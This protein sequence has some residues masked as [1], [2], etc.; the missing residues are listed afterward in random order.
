MAQIFLETYSVTYLLNLLK[1]FKTENIKNINIKILFLNDKSNFMTY[2]I[3]Y[4]FFK[5]IEFKK[6][7]FSFDGLKDQENITLGYKIEKKI[8]YKLFEKIYNNEY[9]NNLNSKIDKFN[10]FAIFLIKYASLKNFSDKK[11]LVQLLITIYACLDKLKKKNFFPKKSIYIIG[12]CPWTNEI[13]SIFSNTGL[14][15]VTFKNFKFNFFEYMRIF[16]KSNNFINKLLILINKT[17]RLDKNFKKNEGYLTTID[18]DLN[19]FQIEKFWKLENFNFKNEII[20]ISKSHYPTEEKIRYFKKNNINFIYFSSKIFFSKEKMESKIYSSFNPNKINFE[21][22]KNTINKDYILNINYL[23]KKEKDWWINYFQKAN[24][25]VFFTEHLW[26]PHCVAAIAAIRELGGISCLLQTSYYD[27]LTPYTITNSDIFFCFSKKS[28]E[29]QKKIDFNNRLLICSGYPL[30]YRYNETNNFDY[31]KNKINNSGATKIISYFDVN[32]HKGDSERWA[33]GK[34]IRSDY[35]FLLKKVIENKWLGLIIK[36]KNPL[37]F[38]SSIGP[39]NDL[40]KKALDTNRCYLFSKPHN[41][42]MEISKISDLS[43]HSVLRAGTSG[44]EAALFK[45]P[46]F[47][48]DRDNWKES[49]LYVLQK[50]K[51]I[52]NSIES[53]WEKIVGDWDN[54]L[55]ENISIWKKNFKYFNNY[56]DNKSNERVIYFLDLLNFYFLKGKTKN[57]VL[58]CASKDYAKKW[59]DENIFSLK[60]NKS[61]IKFSN[62]FA[63]N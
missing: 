60:K 51:V 55:N 59:G 8:L 62:L 38:Q 29:I 13:N 19:L 44:I 27:F 36:P 63:N 52:F 2:I 48:L 41:L 5:N 42:N 58:D 34:V 25:K 46:T 50:D 18:A 4:L 37:N 17:M 54:I 39:I 11:D 21:I 10:S 31:I 22:E 56:N 23:Y 20:F 49:D 61:N 6:F 24:T 57:E 15:I 40:L 7:E 43:I 28:M 53:L 32:F 14:K 26:S 30:D 16:I 1:Y 47:F 12:N 9:L 45:K 35:K 3:K 33:S